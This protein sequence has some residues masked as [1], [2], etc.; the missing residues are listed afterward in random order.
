MRERRALPA[1]RYVPPLGSRKW[2]SG[3][4]HGGRLGAALVS[5][6]SLVARLR[7]RRRTGSGHDRLG[8]K[9]RT[10]TS[11]EP[12]ADASSATRTD[13]AVATPETGAASTQA[14]VGSTPP[15]RPRPANSSTAEVPDVAPPDAVRDHIAGVATGRLLVFAADW[16]H[17]RVESIEFFGLATVRRRMSVDF[18]L[19]RGP[20]WSAIAEMVRHAEA[21]ER[22]V[23]V[24]LTT[25]AKAKLARFDLRDECGQTLPLLTTAQNGERA[26]AALVA[27][28]RTVR[29]RQGRETGAAGPLDADIAAALRLIAARPADQARLVLDCLRDGVDAHAV[30]LGRYGPGAADDDPGFFDAVQRLRC[31]EA[32]GLELLRDNALGPLARKLATDFIVLV[33]LRGDVLATPDPKVRL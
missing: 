7:A 29:H 5:L 28:A 21:E 16:V 26:G 8:E 19:P 1:R 12:T 2:V 23:Y 9:G 32:Q 13:E 20:A 3:G 15:A 18:S 31:K 22:D 11:S 30:A 6:S 24:P 25:L 17:R 14:G 10:P 33:A 27:L 4:A